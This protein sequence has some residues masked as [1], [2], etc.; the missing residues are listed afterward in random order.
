M[1]CSRFFSDPGQ[2]Q[3]IFMPRARPALRLSCKVT[4]RRFQSLR[5]L[6]PARYFLGSSFFRLY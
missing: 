1:A 6:S 3:T 2:A 5:N 4:P